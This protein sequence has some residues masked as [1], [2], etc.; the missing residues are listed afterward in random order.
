MKNRIKYFLFLI[1]L[2]LSVTP[3]SAKDVK[4]VQTVYGVH[5]VIETNLG[6]VEWIFTLATFLFLTGQVLIVNGKTL[7]NQLKK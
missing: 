3:I 1:I 5:D 2:M 6:G 4:G 7:K